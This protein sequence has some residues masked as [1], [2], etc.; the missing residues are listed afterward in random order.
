[1][2]RAR[3]LAVD[4]QLYFRVFLEDLLTQEGYEV[5]TAS[6]GEEA[7][8]LFE[9]GDF[10][11][12]LTDLVMPGL[13]GTQLVQRVKALRPEQEVVVITSVGDVKTAVEAMKLGATDYLLKPIDRTVLARAL[14]DILQRRRLREEHARLMA[15]NLEF[16]GEFSLYE[17]GLGLFATLS[18]EALADRI[19]ESLCLE[20][21]AHGGV[22]WLA[23][24]GDPERMRLVGVRGLVRPEE[25]PEELSLESLPP[26]LAP[27]AEPLRHSFLAGAGGEEAKEDGEPRAQALWVALRRGG[28]L[29]GAVRLTDR[30]DG[31]EFGDAQRA[32][33]E[34]FAVFAAQAVDNA[35]RFQA[36]ERRSFRDPVTKAYTRAYFDD[37]IHNEIRKAARFG[38]TFSLVRLE[39]EGLGELRGRAPEAEF[40]AWLESLV[41]HVGRALRATD[42]LAAESESRFCV[43]L[44]ET[45]SVGAAVLKRRIRAA[46]ERSEPWRA[47]EAEERP[48]LLLGA[49]TF[50]T[51][52]TQLE[53]LWGALEA[54]VDEDRR[55][56][57]RSLELEST[58]FRGLVDALLGEGISGR[59]ETGEQ[60][61]RYL[62][63]EVARRPHE[64]G[65]LFVAPGAGMAG[66]LRD[67]LETLRG[68]SPRTE[69]VLVAERKG[70]PVSGLPVTW[71]SPLRAGTQAPFL[72]YFGEGSPY[73]LL[74]EPASD[75]GRVTLF[76]TCDRV[77]VEHLT[78][79]LGRDLGIP[80]GE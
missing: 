64:R 29:L 20:T 3:I 10:D 50:P 15:E 61:T 62:I 37:V 63:D 65:L 56:L 57:V 46:V 19:V 9:R 21:H 2:P 1:M 42:L 51:D 32:A 41:F 55:S 48:V 66:A 78:F 39:L 72:I 38:R 77:L 5:C 58:P 24:D 60:M 45:D 71:V 73:A 27:L 54:R 59:P 79:Q 49:A 67:G 74:R 8:H 23:R 68:L 25:E 53:A 13:D 80:V 47:L 7:L 4:D 76:H 14:E 40:V 12:V 6:G 31:G 52:G 75:E 36:L 43:L 16:M 70:A 33:G 44:P 11:V 28:T 22:L 30:L 17:R 18:L 34:K 69:I 35:L 26:E